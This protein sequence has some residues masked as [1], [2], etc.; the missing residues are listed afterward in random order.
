MWNQLQQYEEQKD[1]RISM[2]NLVDIRSRQ[3]RELT[4][5]VYSPFFH[6]SNYSESKVPIKVILYKNHEV[7]YEKTLQPGDMFE[8]NEQ[9]D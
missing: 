4:T 1:L 5:K 6:V 8:R 2:A 3:T 9:L 7:K